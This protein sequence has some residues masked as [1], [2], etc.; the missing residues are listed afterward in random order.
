MLIR[1]K[2]WHD[3]RPRCMDLYSGADFAREPGRLLVGDSGG[4]NRV[5]GIVGGNARG[6]AVT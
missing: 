3:Q 6:R 1:V 4:L 5:G 2:T